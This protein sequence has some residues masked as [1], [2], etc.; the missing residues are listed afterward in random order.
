MRPAFK[1][2]LGA[3]FVRLLLLAI[4]GGCIWYGMTLTGLGTQLFAVTEP[5]RVDHPFRSDHHPRGAKMAIAGGV[6]DV[7]GTAFGGLAF[8]FGGAFALMLFIPWM[9][10][11]TPKREN[12]TAPGIEKIPR[13][14]R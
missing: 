2:F 5:M 10:V 12:D 1:A 4:A 13:A 9:R 14:A 3:F 6:I 7:V 11:F 8:V